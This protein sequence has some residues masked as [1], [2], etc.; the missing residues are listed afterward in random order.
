MA[1]SLCVECRWFD[2][3][4]DLSR[5]SHYHCRISDKALPASVLARPACRDFSAPQ[6]APYWGP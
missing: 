4:V 2:L 3:Q 6:P 5:G 1:K